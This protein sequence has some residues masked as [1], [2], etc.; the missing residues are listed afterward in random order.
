[1]IY[2][3]GISKFFCIFMEG[4]FALS[5]HKTVRDVVLRISLAT[6]LPILAIDYR[7]IP[8]HPFQL[9]EMMP[10]KLFNG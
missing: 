4:A 8:Q 9:R 1:M 6:K 3:K 2:E 5:T 10:L 7:K